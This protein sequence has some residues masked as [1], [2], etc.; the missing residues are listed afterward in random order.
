MALTFHKMGAN[1]VITSFRDRKP[2]SQDTDVKDADVRRG[3]SSSPFGRR[4]ILRGREEWGVKI[5]VLG[6]P[7]A[8]GC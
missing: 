7:S 4:A 1:R 3:G 8:E 2:W 5:L 6:S